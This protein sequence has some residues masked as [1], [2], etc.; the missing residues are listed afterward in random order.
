MENGRRQTSVEGT[1][2]KTGLG[3]K[4]PKMARGGEAEQINQHGP[5]EEMEK[6]EEMAAHV[7]DTQESVKGGLNPQKSPQEENLSRE[8]SRPWEEMEKGRRW[9]P[10]TS[11]ERQSWQLYPWQ[12]QHLPP[13]HTD[14]LWGWIL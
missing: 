10:V 4:T 14:I 7:S 1:P 8:S 12:L 9:L 3:V 11:E 5:L 2:K 6:G 13:A